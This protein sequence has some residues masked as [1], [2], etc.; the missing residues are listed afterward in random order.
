MRG[1]VKKEIQKDIEKIAQGMDCQKDFICY[2]SDFTHI[3]K[4]S[5]FGFE[6]VLECGE[7]K[8]SDCSFARKHLNTYQCTCPVR[9]YIKKKLEK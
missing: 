7:E 2:T 3:C 8:P 9:A 6:D 5:I 1:S 4:V